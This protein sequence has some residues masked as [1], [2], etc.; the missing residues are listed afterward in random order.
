MIITSHT[1]SRRRARF[2]GLVVTV[3]LM[4]L[5]GNAVASS[6]PP[7]PDISARGYLLMDYHSG[8]I[9]AE[10]NAS[11]RLEPAS[12]TKMMTAYIVLNELK[13]GK[14][15]LHD[16][17]LIS[18]K[19]WRMPGSRTF[20]EVGKRVA[21]ETL[22]KGM[23]IQSGNDASV[24]LAEYVAGDETVFAKL[25]NRTAKGLGMSATNFVNST[26]LPHDDHYTNAR[27][28]AILARA[29]IRDFP[30]HYSLYSVREFTYN[31]ITQYNRNK[32]LWQDD[33]VDG[34]KTGHTEAAGY[35]LVSS[36]ERD[37]MR[38]ISVVL[39]AKS[40]NGRARESQKL[41]SYGFR[42]FE[43]HRL[44]A[45][46]E[47]LTDVR[48]WKGATEQLPLGIDAELYVTIPRG[49]YDNLNANLKVSP[50][51]TAPVESGKQYGMLEVSLNGQAVAS[52]PL[53]ALQDIA[54]GGFFTRLKDE[55]LLL[56]E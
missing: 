37:D 56:F 29:L 3:L 38:L 36:A 24:A 48:I 17:V 46:R 12:L 18:E 35:C 25:M 7:P 50:T 49:Q 40:E 21:L 5:G 6:A 33:S 15:H 42:F 14:I 28:M 54:E 19:A 41:L 9:L 52:Q 11:E 34:V 51:I 31:G 45:P 39:G 20:V 55:A 10:Q 30:E 47:K 43:T 4:L 26:G 13:T 32:L 22:L 1:T 27:D 2:N 23:I 44:Y 8:Q 53:I 16:E